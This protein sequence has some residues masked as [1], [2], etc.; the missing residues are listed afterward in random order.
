MHSDLTSG[1][2][3]LGEVMIELW[4]RSPLAQA[5]KLQL[6]YSGDVLNIAV[7]VKRLGL[8]SAIITRLGNDPFGDYLMDEWS[9]LGVNLKHVARGDEPTGLYISEYGNYGSYETWY[10]RKGSAASTISSEDINSISLDAASMVHVSGIS[11]A[12]SDS[13]RLATRRLAERG[14][15]SQKLVSFDLNYRAR[16][17]APDAARQAAEEIIPLTN[18]FFAGGEE[19]A[20]IFGPDDPPTLAD[21]A[22][23]LGAEIAAISL[24]ERGAYVAWKDGSFAI[25][26][27]ARRLEG[28][29]GAGDAFAGGF[30]A[31]VMLN[32]E[33]STCA[34]IGT[35]VAGLKV[36]RQ[37]P[38]LGLPFQDDVR[39]RAA[40]LGWHDVTCALDTIASA[41]STKPIGNDELLP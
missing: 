33:P 13:S 40:E 27:V 21:R 37:G 19:G 35:V 25:K 10:Y 29:Q 26:P 12:I 8:P 20:T 41:S 28:L 4:G 14:R 11:Q 24:A 2:L 18:V 15:A 22:L 23:E 38:L 5:T 31:G 39:M 30:A 32:Q 1:F 9:K 6:T 3:S 16:L 36:E 7:A 34:R 17:W